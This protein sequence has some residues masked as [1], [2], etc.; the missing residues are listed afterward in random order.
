MG[1]IPCPLEQ[2]PIVAT[3]VSLWAK[4]DRNADQQVIGWHSLVDHSADVDAVVEALL[5]QPT[6][7][8]RL[9]QAAGQVALDPVTSARLVALAFLHDIGKANRGFRRRIDP[10]APPVGHIDQ[11]A[12]IFKTT[13]GR[14]YAE[15]L[16][17]VLGLE[18]MEGWFAADDAFELWDTIFAHHGRPWSSDPCDAEAY[19]KQGADGSDPIAELVQMR[20]ALYGWFAAVFTLGPPLPA[21]PAFHHAFAG[22]LMLADWLGSDT[23]FFPFAHG[24][25]AARMTDA[26]IGAR[27]ALHAVG[28]AVG[29]PAHRDTGAGTRFSGPVR[30]GVPASDSTGRHPSRRALRCLGGGDRLRQDGGGT[31]AL[32][33]PVRGR[34][35]RWAV[36]RPADSRRSHTD[37]RAGG[38]VP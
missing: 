18:R 17:T 19:W 3:A 5:D 36:F 9:A 13:W 1:I 11:L 8:Q 32:P 31:L 4:L 6:I 7:R 14:P 23:Q 25:A 34:R 26:R 22:L 21:E 30:R 33:P 12:W 38:A 20:A 16:N 2:L 28:L 35:S 37:V 15:K 24:A 10:H 29:K 27:T